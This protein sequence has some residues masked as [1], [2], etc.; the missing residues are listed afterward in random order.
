MT[1]ARRD[2]RNCGTTGVH[3]FIGFVY[4]L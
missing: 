4:G 1:E 2:G 3:Y